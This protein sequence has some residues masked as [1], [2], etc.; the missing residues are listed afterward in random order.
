MR[1]EG[2][3]VFSAKSEVLWAL[4]HDPFTLEQL[5]PGCEA[6]EPGAA[7][8]FAVTLSLRVGQTIER[9]VGTLQ[10]ERATSIDGFVFR[11]EGDSPNGSVSSRGRVYLEE[12]GSGATAV[13]YEADVEV[14]G[15][16]GTLSPRLLETT[17]RA[18]TR[19]CLETLERQVALRTRVY[20]TSISLPGESRPAPPAAAIRQL[21]LVR[22]ALTVVVFLMTALFLWR[23]I[24]YR[25]TRQAMKILAH[26]PAAEPEREA[27]APSH[28]V[29]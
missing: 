29:A 25:R 24:N 26:S 17:A 1:I 10:L 20:T 22:R 28:F 5:L 18:F 27:D 13:R 3:Q 9:F 14:D 23:G 6:F 8:E 15:R 19:R 16:L 7:G 21:A 12:E 4:L 2:Q 11:A